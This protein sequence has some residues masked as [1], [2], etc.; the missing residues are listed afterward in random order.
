MKGRLLSFRVVLAVL[1][2]FFMST[3]GCAYRYRFKTDLP[4]SEKKVTKWYHIGIW[5]TV[6]SRPFNLEQACP[7]GVA[8]FG[9]YVSF[10]N[11][12]PAIITIGLYS[13]RT[14]YAICSYNKSG[15]L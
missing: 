4:S 13:P 14:V 8:E 1:C 5:G 12:L 15:E 11:W 7:G 9:S 6:S 2:I 3:T 10:F